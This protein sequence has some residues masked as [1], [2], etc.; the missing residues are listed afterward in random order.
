VRDGGYVG[1]DL[2]FLG[3]TRIKRRSITDC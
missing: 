3:R 2:D 1:C